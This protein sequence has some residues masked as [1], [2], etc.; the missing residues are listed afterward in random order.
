M[1]T[2]FLSL[3]WF[4]CPSKVVGLTVVFPEDLG[5]RKDG[6][7]STWMLREFQLLEGIRDAR[8]AAAYLCQ[9]AHWEYCPR[10]SIFEVGCRSVWPRLETL[11]DRLV[12]KGPLPVACYCGRSHSPM[13]GTTD[14]DD[15]IT[16]LFSSLGTKFWNHCVFDET[17]EARDTSLRD[18][19]TTDLA[20]LKLVGIDLAHCALFMT[21]GRWETLQLPCWQIFQELKGRTPLWRPRPCIASL[22]CPLRVPF[23]ALYRRLQRFLLRMPL[24]RRLLVLHLVLHLCLS[25]A[26]RALNRQERAHGLPRV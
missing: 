24:C 17:L 21:L 16:S 15:F 7:T 2:R 18:G 20:P 14:S 12:Y 22:Y 6:P 4:T 9:I 19:A 1:R 25:P 5:G 26:L 13:I 10:P 23:C 3:V 11:H 8:R